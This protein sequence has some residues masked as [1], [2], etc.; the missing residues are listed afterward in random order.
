[1]SHIHRPP[2]TTSTPSSDDTTTP[3]YNFWMLKMLDGIVPYLDAKDS[4]TLLVFLSEVPALTPAALARVKD[5]ARDPERVSLALSALHYLVLFRPPVRT[6]CID[7][8]EDLW[9]NCELLGSFS[10]PL[11]FPLVLRPAVC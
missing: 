10:L 7:A 4:K 5:I 1:M 9:R 3:T 2:A 6:A 8:M 11:P